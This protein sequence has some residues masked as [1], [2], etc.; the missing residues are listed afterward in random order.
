MLSEA[1][2]GDRVSVLLGNYAAAVDKIGIVFLPWILIT[3]ESQ[4]DTVSSCII[5][6]SFFLILTGPY[7]WEALL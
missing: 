7:V 5:V 3:S 6:S 1:V 2:S 4:M